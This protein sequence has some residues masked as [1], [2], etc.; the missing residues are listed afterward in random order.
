MS[1]I[2]TQENQEQEQTS[3][4][5]RN[6]SFQAA[7]A[8]AAGPVH[9]QPRCA[10]APGAEQ[11]G[12]VDWFRKKFS[13]STEADGGEAETP[14]E[15]TAPLDAELQAGPQ[16][17]LAGL[18]RQLSAS[19]KFGFWG[20]SDYFDQVVQSIDQVSQAMG[21]TFTAQL[22]DNLRLLS[23]AQ[24]A[25]QTL[26]DRCMEYTARR[27]KTS[28]GKARRAIVLEIQKLAGRDLLG[29]QDAVSD[30]CGMSPE[31]QAGQTWQT[32]L[33]KAR[34]IRLS[35]PDYRALNP[36]EGGQLSEVY[37]L[38]SGSASVRTGGGTTPLDKTV[39]FKPEDSLDI[40]APTGAVRLPSYYVAWNETRKQFPDLSKQDTACIQAFVN[41]RIMGLSMMNANFLEE[42]LSSRGVD[43]IRYLVAK[44]KDLGTLVDDIL[45]PSGTLNQSGTFNSTRR[46]VA[47]SRMAAL[48]G[49]DHLVA[50]SQTAEIYDEATQR[51]YQ[52]NIMEQAEGVPYNQLEKT[53][54][55]GASPFTAGFQRDMVNLQVL[56]VLCGQS[57]RHMN[58]IF[59]RRDGNGT[60][61]GLTGID[62]DASFGL[63]TDV[64]STEFGY[65]SDRRVYDP[66]SGKMVLP[67]MDD[68]LAQRISALD[69]AAV[70]YALQDLLQD[71]EVNAAIQR[72]KLMK[73]AIA[74]ARQEQADHPEAPRRFLQDDEWNEETARNMVQSTKESLAAWGKDSIWSAQTNAAQMAQTRALIVAYYKITGVPNAEDAARTLLE[75]PPSQR[76]EEQSRVFHITNKWAN[77]NNAR[78]VAKKTLAN[79]T[80]FGSFASAF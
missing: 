45:G 58:N 65:R 29:L 46:N 8:P 14:A 73:A 76:T 10:V 35:V 72:L 48:L 53:Q 6:A 78:R 60:F 36:A 3:Q 57:D 70:R 49:L 75:T 67:Y 13:A 44:Q 43:A 52:G 47:T 42:E 7:P 9:A 31:E 27:P 56:D 15:E 66:D 26:L 41:D 11:G 54:A 80:Y 51:T 33:N 4:Q 61:S 71:A 40:T 24:A 38:K 19:S 50:K 32:V 17:E 34:A 23:Q 12:I 69:E 68:A 25:C 55:E 21:G 18:A 16:T 77:E 37:R 64:V 74:D 22:T 1:R 79:S 5:T 62:N 30:F 28:S 63:N 20:N 59:F 39:F 2:Y